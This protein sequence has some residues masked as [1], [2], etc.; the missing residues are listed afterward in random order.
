MECDAFWLQNSVVVDANTFM[1]PTQQVCL[2]AE[3]TGVAVSQRA[4]ES[5]GIWRERGG[6]RTYPKIIK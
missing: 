1:I 3:S 5:L 4:A 2:W 6:L